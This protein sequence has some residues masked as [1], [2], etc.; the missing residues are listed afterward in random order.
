MLESCTMPKKRL[1]NNSPSNFLPFHV[2]SAM[3]RWEPEY[4]CTFYFGTLCGQ[5]RAHRSDG[6][7]EGFS[8][9]EERKRTDPI[10][11]SYSDADD[12]RVVCCFKRARIILATRASDSL[13]SFHD[14]NINDCPSLN[15]KFFVH[16]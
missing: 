3:Y 2:F 8:A 10:K 6:T 11:A 9:A 12:I 13:V 5:K 1:K 4:I 14:E 7:I 16:I 15:A